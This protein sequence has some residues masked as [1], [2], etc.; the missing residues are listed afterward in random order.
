MAHYLVEDLTQ[1]SVEESAWSRY[2]SSFTG[3]RRGS[4]FIESLFNL[5]TGFGM[6]AAQFVFLE[7]DMQKDM[8]SFERAINYYKG[9]ARNY[10]V[11]IFFRFF[12]SK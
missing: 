3:R 5:F 2:C 12:H 9:V 4:D 6:A 10:Q 7:R 8:D 11:S 1:G